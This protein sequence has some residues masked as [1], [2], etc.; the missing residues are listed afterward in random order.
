MEKDGSITVIASE[1][2]GKRRNSP[3]DIVVRRDGNVYF[4]DP[5]SKAVLEPQELGFNG[6]Y[7]V[8]PQ[9]K[10]SLIGAKMPFS[11]GLK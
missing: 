7:H 11:W 2:Q 5:V 6:L 3:N 8:T 9:G 4:S 10:L 1:W